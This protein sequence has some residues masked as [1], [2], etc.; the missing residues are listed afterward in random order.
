MRINPLPW[1]RGDSLLTTW[2]PFKAQPPNTTT[3]TSKFHKSSEG[4][5]PHSV[6]STYLENRD[7][8]YLVSCPHSD[9]GGLHQELRGVVDVFEFDL[10]TIVNKK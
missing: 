7:Q 8:K 5:K 9:E 4:D 1:E 3:M 10:T 2:L 6:H